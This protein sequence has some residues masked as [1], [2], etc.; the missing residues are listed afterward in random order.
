LLERFRAL[1]GV[2]AAGII[3]P[4]PLDFN[5][6]FTEFTID[7]QSPTSGRE[8]FRAENATVDGGFFDAAGMAIVAGRTFNDGDRRDSQPV[9]IISQAMARRYWPGGDAL[10]RI[11]RRPDPAEPDLMVVGVASDI[12][13]QSLGETPRDVIYE[14]YTQGE[15]SAGFA[16]VVRA[17]TDPARMSLTL[18]TAAREI[19]P[20]LQVV[21]S[22]T[23]AQHLAMSRLP[24]Q[25]GAVL[26]SAF[27]A[28]GMALAAVGVFGM[29]RYTVAM[30]TRE[31]GIRMALGADA[32][33]VARLLATHG[34][35]LVLVGCA[36]GV[37]ASLV[38][39]RF[40]STLLFGVGTFDPVALIG[41]PLV[42]GVAAW[43]AAYLPARRASR[44]DPLAALRTD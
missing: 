37:A 21:Q 23:M 29:V 33:A 40:L 32:A 39:A 3:W 11:L 16:F 44:M 30:R 42:L 6:S 19:D 14:T 26:L 43:L 22:T 12:N 2:D 15:R 38:A 8:A 1:P 7:G 31:V 5:S 25:I 10:G 41:A 24:S 4:L 18:V 13:V 28:M 27:A 34:L 17:A 9:A 20:D 35:R 36:I